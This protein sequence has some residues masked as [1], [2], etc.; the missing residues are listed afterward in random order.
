MSTRHAAMAVICALFLASCGGNN[1]PPMNVDS[2]PPSRVTDLA[3]VSAT[4]TSIT[5]QWTAPGDD[6]TTGK[7]ASYILRRS[8]VILNE[9]TFGSATTISGVPAPGASGTTEL[10]TVPGLDSNITYHFALRARDDAGNPSPVSNDAMWMPHGV[11]QHYNKTI[12]PF[13]DNTMYAEVDTFSNALGQHVYAGTNNNNARPRRGLMAF[14]IADSIPAGAVIDSVSL[15]LNES[16][17]TPYPSTAIV[18]LHV[19]SADW[20]EGTST[21]TVGPGEGGG[22]AGT[23]GDATWKYRFMKTSTW[24]T[25]GGDFTATTSASTPTTT[26]LGVYTWK[27]AQ[28]AA[29]VQAWLDSPATN[30]GWILIGDEAISGTARQFDS[31]ENLTVSKRPKLTIYYT[32]NP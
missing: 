18:S 2:T 5:L 17:A 22:G 28:M 24:I 30:F 3:V 23:P 21:G 8:D 4:A 25:L 12:P 14:A 13:R 27:S 29:D 10:F 6:G 19:L 31:R 26:T 32:I 11:P 9:T 16:K 15:A 1:N 20:G 7:A